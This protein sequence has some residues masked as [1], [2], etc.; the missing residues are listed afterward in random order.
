MSKKMLYTVFAASLI[1]AMILTG[2]GASGTPSATAPAVVTEPATAPA[3]E[4]VTIEYWTFGEFANTQAM[5]DAIAEF[6]AA[7]PN[8]TVDVVGKPDTEIQA[9]IIAGASSGQIPDVYNIALNVGAEMLKAGALKDI[10]A[11]WNALPEDYRNQ[12]APGAVQALNQGGAVYGIPYTAY[13]TVLYRN[14][15]VLEEAGIDPSKGIKDW[16]DWADQMSKVKAAGYTAL[17]NYSVDGWLVFHFLGGVQGITN[18]IVDGKSS[19]TV[20][21]LTKAYQFLL[22]TKPFG[23][24]VGPFDAAASDLFI[25]DQMAFYE[26]GPWADTTFAAAAETNPNFK[27]DVVLMPGEIE[28]WSGGTHGGEFFGIAPG[29]NAEAALKLAVFLADKAQVAKISAEFGGR[30]TYNDAAMADPSLSTYALLA[31]TVEAASMGL[32][33][34]AYFQAFPLAVRQP[35]ADNAAKA[36]DGVLTPE[37]AAQAAIDAVNAEIAKASQ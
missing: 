34:A 32:P 15:T 36:R 2:C 1:V 31:L 13:A 30:A 17:P 10:S 6:Q 23:T 19:I 28:G 25:N 11:E 35:L 5:K 9:G 12:F 22:D 24:D 20:A 16:A 7:N 18:T 26:M 21:Q 8:I 14:L 4:P 33:D 27:Y 3:T 29:P 37:A